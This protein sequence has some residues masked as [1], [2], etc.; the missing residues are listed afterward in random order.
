VSGGIGDPLYTVAHLLGALDVLQ[1]FTNLEVMRGKAGATTHFHLTVISSISA[2]AVNSG[3]TVYCSIMAGK[4]HFAASFAPELAE[5]LPGSKTTLIEPGRMRT[6]F[7]KGSDR[8][9]SR[10]MDPMAVAEGI[11]SAVVQQQGVFQELIVRKNPD[12]TPRFEIGPQLP[13]RPMN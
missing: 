9:T 7:F 11:W 6:D 2:F 4:S 12:C 10:Y 8:D 13:E 5:L 3:S 1:G